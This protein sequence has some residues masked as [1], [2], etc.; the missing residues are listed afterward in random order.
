MNMNCAKEFF[1]GKRLD[2]S[3]KGTSPQRNKKEKK[4]MAKYMFSEELGKLIENFIQEKFDA[5]T[6]LWDNPYHRD[7]R[8]DFQFNEDCLEE[9]LTFV[10]ENPIFEMDYDY[11]IEKCKDEAFCKF[12]YKNITK[13]YEDIKEIVDEQC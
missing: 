9:C 4:Q 5:A 1:Y 7:Y 10:M 13:I 8:R 3:L 2:I 12:L 11:F 6:E